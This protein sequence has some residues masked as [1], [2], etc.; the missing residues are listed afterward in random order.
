MIVKNSVYPLARN[1]EFVPLILAAV[2]AFLYFGSERII[3]K[4]I[5]PI[6]LIVISACLGIFVF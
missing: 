4:K 5:S 3:K 6:M 2:L 1:N